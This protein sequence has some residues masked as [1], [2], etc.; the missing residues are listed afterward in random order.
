MKF[1]LLQVAIAIDQLLNAVFCGGWADE[2]MSSN[3]WRMDQRKGRWGFM[4]PVI[5][6]LAWNIFRD[7]NHCE[8]SHRSERL[9][10]QSPPEDR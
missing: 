4:R 7:A 5:D 3:S 6:W 10:L 2:T 8:M 9:R 1:W